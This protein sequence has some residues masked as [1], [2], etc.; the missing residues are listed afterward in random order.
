MNVIETNSEND[1][2]SYLN[3]ENNDNNS[4]VSSGE[5]NESNSDIEQSSEEINVMEEQKKIM[6]N[7]VSE[8]CKLDDEI[9]QLKG[10]IKERD[11]RLKEL[12][13]LISGFMS[14]NSVDFFNLQ[15]G[16]SLNYKETMKYKSLNKTQ[17]LELYTM[18]LG[19]SE[20]AQKLLNFLKTNREKI[21]NTNLLRKKN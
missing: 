15:T 11:K 10:G 19:D 6:K 2:E 3:E 13:A 7:Y 9:K 21:P 16:G 8:Y 14:N 5:D 1:T 12:K 18:F 4:P 20:K 17:T